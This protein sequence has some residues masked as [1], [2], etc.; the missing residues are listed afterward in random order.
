[1]SDSKPKSEPE[2]ELRVDV[3]P[4]RLEEEW[5]GQAKQVEEWARLA[6]DAQLEYDDAKA[7]LEVEK[8]R[9]AAEIRE[10]PED[11]GLDRVTEQA[12]DK[13][14]PAQPEYAAAVKRVN[15]AKHNMKIHD[16]AV[17]AL[18]HRKRALTKAV[19]LWMAG[20]FSVPNANRPI[21]RFG[22]EDKRHIRS[23]ARRRQFQEAIA[24]EENNEDDD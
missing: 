17:L 13:T 14:I 10:H 12:I 8:A 4:L 20:Y 6:A 5:F 7:N 23:R 16:A 21:E 19:D 9:L 11:Y 22:D 3:D 1:M 24:G 15:Q 18:E 2:P